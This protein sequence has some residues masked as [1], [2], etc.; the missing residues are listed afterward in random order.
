MLV[1]AREKLLAARRLLS[2]KI[3]PMEQAKLEAIHA[4]IAQAHKS[5]AISG[6][7]LEKLRLEARA[8]M[9]IKKYEWQLGL[10]MPTLGNRPTWRG[11]PCR[12]CHMRRNTAK[13]FP[14]LSLREAANLANEQRGIE[15]V[16]TA[17]AH[18]R[19]ETPL[20]LR[21][22]EHHF[23]PRRSRAIA[24]PQVFLPTPPVSFGL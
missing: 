24:R 21:G 22:Y 18:G 7:R 8:P 6:E 16:S 4:S 5:K 12:M 23:H 19:S 2:D 11:A 10:V 14:K 9:T 17:N 20:H 15:L 1:D 13:R 3:D